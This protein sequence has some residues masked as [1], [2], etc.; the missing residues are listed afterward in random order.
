MPENKF[1][2]LFHKS[3]VLIKLS[4]RD[5]NNNVVFCDLNEIVRMY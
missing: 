2:K 4:N 5:K 3:E 1:K